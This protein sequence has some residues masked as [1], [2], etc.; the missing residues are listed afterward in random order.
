MTEIAHANVG[1]MG[2]LF[3]E[4]R[5]CEQA[6]V[7]PFLAPAQICF[8]A[9]FIVSCQKHTHCQVG[10]YHSGAMKDS[11]LLECEVM[12]IDMKLFLFWRSQLPLSSRS[13]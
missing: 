6:Q 7:M 1:L 13:Q 2:L 5:P 8:T 10:G 9:V 11:S 3:Q 4:I 12:S